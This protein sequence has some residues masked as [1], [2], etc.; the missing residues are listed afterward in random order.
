MASPAYRDV[1]K[2]QRFKNRTKTLVINTDTN[3]L[4]SP[5]KHLF[6]AKKLKK[7]SQKVFPK[8]G[9]SFGERGD[10]SSPVIM[11]IHFRT[12]TKICPQA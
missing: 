9:K 8:T 12:Q 1:L 5:K 7:T 6:S 3:Q 4:F 10:P 11:K 2:V